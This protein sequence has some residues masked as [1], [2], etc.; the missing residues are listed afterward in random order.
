MKLTFIRHTAVQVEKTLCYG[1]TDV[2]LAD[3]FHQEVQT[4]RQTI[5]QTLSNTTYDAA[6]CSPLSRC[7]RLADELVNVHKTEIEFDERLVELDF[8]DWE[9]ADWDSIFASPAGKV[10]F[11][12]YVNIRCPNGEAF[13][14]QIARMASF[15]DQLR[16]A[17]HRHVLV[18]THA[19]CIRAAMCLLHG[20]TP[21]DAFAT[22]LDYGQIVS[23]D[24]ERMI[25]R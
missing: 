25:P 8:G 19:G 23:F 5:K 21:A 22:P 20:R 17:E 7:R 6:Y 15:L 16:A 3:S 12:D 18:F 9:M 1:K 11:D 2:A 24:L 10:W 14:D 13:T 4:I